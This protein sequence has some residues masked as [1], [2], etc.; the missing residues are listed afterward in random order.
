MKGTHK[1]TTKVIIAILLMTVVL[2]GLAIRERTRDDASKYGDNA[3]DAKND[4]V[5]NVSAVDGLKEEVGKQEE[6]TPKIQI[7]VAAYE[8]TYENEMPETM[9]FRTKDT[10]GVLCDIEFYSMIEGV[11][12]SVFSLDIGNDRGDMVE[13]YVDSNGTTVPVAFKMYPIPENLHDTAVEEFCAAQ[14]MV[15]TLAMSLKVKIVDELATEEQEEEKVYQYVIDGYT[16]SFN[17][18]ITDLIQIDLNE[19]KRAIV[20][21]VLLV[22]NTEMFSLYINADEGDI[23]TYVTDSEGNM[24][25]VAF[26]VNSLPDGLD[27]EYALTF[28]RAQEVINDVVQTLQILN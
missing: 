27:E 5:V 19:E 11:E 16:V 2:L 6:D 13:F 7:L 22:D 3:S 23:V 21:S 18:R 8:V 1:R 17:G 10:D 25:P 4:T 14:D 24:I 28:Y 12:V 9:G 26:E 20:F 15:N